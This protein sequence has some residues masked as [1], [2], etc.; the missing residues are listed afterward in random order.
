MFGERVKKSITNLK[1][2]QLVIRP[3]FELGTSKMQVQ[4]I[5]ATLNCMVVKRHKINIY[6]YM[7]GTMLGTNV[8]TQLSG[9]SG[10]CRLTFSKNTDTF[11]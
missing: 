6:L 7:A 4:N 2:Q 10:L 8:T 5:T 11:Q 3:R 9:P 1:L